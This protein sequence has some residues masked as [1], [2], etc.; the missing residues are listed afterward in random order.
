MLA[1]SIPDGALLAVPKDSSGVA[2]SATRELVR[3]GV[4][5][6]HLV[7]VPTS[8][9][10]AEILLGTGAV[11]TLETSAI[12]LG[13]FGV[14]PR[15]VSALREGSVRMLDST[16][17]AV[18]AALQ[19]G[20]KGIPFI[21]LRGLI[22]TDVLANRSD[23]KVIDNPFVPGDPIVLLP[24]IR[25]DVALFHAKL[26]DSKGN[27][28]IGRERELL[29]MSQAAQ[30]ALVTVEELT[31]EDLLADEARAGSVIPSIYV[32]HIALAPRGAWPLELPD[33]YRRDE[34]VLARY[35]SMAGTRE[36]FAAFVQGWLGEPNAAAA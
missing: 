17:P 33:R 35:V 1:A 27:V 23:W 11:K 3:R 21:P 26:A 24:A 28:F 29:I 15:F 22:G 12:T 16:C 34:A 31:D 4:R 9:L 30:R 18:Y 6:L 13:E 2:M 8:G 7:C 20:Q 32:S 14:A 10:Q 5:N 36:G 25:P 19:A